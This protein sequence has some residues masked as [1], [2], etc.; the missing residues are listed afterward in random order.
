MRKSAVKQVKKRSP[1]WELLTHLEKQVSA[2]LMVFGSVLFAIGYGLDLWGGL[3]AYEG[4]GMAS[5]LTTF[6][7]MFQLWG[8][9]IFAVIAGC[10]VGIVGERRVRDEMAELGEIAA[11]WEA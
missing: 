10:L 9:F 3:A 5:F 8:V 4:K 1:W 6:P 2:S 11:R 7:W